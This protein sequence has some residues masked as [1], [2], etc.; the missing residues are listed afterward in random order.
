MDRR[1]AAVLFADVVGFSALAQADEDNAVT[2]LKA[3]I[4][5][6]EPAIAMHA[7]R[8]VKSTGDGFLA[9]FASVVDAVACADAMQKNIAARNLHEPMEKRIQFRMGIHSGDVIVDGADMLGDGVNIAARL[10]SVAKP[11]GIAVLARVYDDVASKLDIPFNDLVFIDLKNMTRPVNVFTVDPSV[12]EPKTPVMDHP[13]KPSIA[14][15]PFENRSADE[16]NAYFTDGVTEDITVALAQVP[17]VFVVARNSSYSSKG[18]AIDVRRVGRELGVRYVLE[19][20]V[21]KSSKRLR[22]TTELIET[23]A[24]TTLWSKQFDGVLED[25]FDLQDEV[26]AAV[27]TS[28][29]PEIQTAEI[30]RVLKNPSTTLEPM[31]CINAGSMQCIWGVSMRR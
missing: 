12:A 22:I 13:D 14:V 31:T 10:E 20:S 5:A 15:L 25:I 17:W 6:L 18:L 16:E 30:S 21:Q 23:E 1:L 11:G 9:E 24:G 26:S 19:G 28:I 7:G 27:V 2:T 4:T 8:I 3:H 29:A